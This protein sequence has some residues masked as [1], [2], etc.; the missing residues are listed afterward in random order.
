[1]NFL[2]DNTYYVQMAAMSDLQWS[3]HD[4]TTLYMQKNGELS[5]RDNILCPKYV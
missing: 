4:L 1:M 5:H 2:Y 3:L